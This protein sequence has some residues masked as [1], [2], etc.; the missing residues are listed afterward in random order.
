MQVTPTSFGALSDGTQAQLYSIH[1]AAGMELAV[2]DLGGCIVSIKVPDAAGQLVDVVLGCDDAAGY[3]KDMQNLGAPIGRVV[4]RIAGASFSLDGVTYQ[5]TANDGENCNHGGRDPW[6]LR[7]WDVVRAEQNEDGGVIEL[8]LVSPDGDQGFPGQIDLHMTYELTAATDVA[9]G[10]L[11]VTYDGT[12]A[13]NTLVNMTN[14][15]Y[16]NLNGASTGSVL[17]HRLVVDADCYTETDAHLIPTGRVVPTDGLV[18]D[19][20]DGKVLGDVVRSQDASVVKAKGLDHNFVLV[21][22]DAGE[23]GFV[24]APRHAARLV[25]EKTGITLDISTDLPG[26]QVYTGNYLE[27]GEGKGGQ[28]YHDYDAVALETNFYADAIHHPNFPQ[29]VFG[30]DRPYR[31]RTVYSFSAH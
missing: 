3:E 6:R 15:S 28:V 5:L 19:L 7:V 14:H 16:F 1:N 20:H 2:T 8:R 10:A 17:G 30:P 18:L 23:N 27:G 31:S 13:A 12:P 29:P 11:V 25:G 9:V 24:G 26:I 22:A 4:N 21:P